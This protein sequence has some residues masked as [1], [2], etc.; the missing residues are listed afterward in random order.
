MDNSVEPHIKGI[1]FIDFGEYLIERHGQNGFKRVLDAVDPSVGTLLEKAYGHEWYPLRALVEC[2]ERYV[3]LFYEGDPKATA[4]FGK[5]DAIRQVGSIYR[6]ILRHMSTPF[7]LKRGPM[8]WKSYMDRGICEPKQTGPNRFEVE[9]KDY[10]PIH[11]VHCY[12]NVGSFEGALEVCGAKN[13]K[14]EH[15]ACRLEGAPACHYI[16]TWQ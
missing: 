7:L 6:V 9:L 16:A 5:F 11:Q 3:E 13:A 1:S 4:L 8:I 2:E 14:V 15:V 10:S 12:E